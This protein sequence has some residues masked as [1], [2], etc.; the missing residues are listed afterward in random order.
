MDLNNKA[1]MSFALTFQAMANATSGLCEKSDE[2]Q[3]RA[4]T[5]QQVFQTVRSRATRQ[6]DTR[7]NN[8]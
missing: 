7:M 1:T 2:R 8:T 5:G 3:V 4:G 6:V